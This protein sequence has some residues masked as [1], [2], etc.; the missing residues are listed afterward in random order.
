MRFVKITALLLLVV[1]L[2]A[3]A[4]PVA[5]AADKVKVTFM[6]WEG[7]DTNAVIDKAVESFKAANPDIDVQRLETP[8]TDYSQKIASMTVANQL[9]DIFWA[10]N[11]TEQ[12][13]GAQGALYDWTATLKGDKDLKLEDFAP[14]AIEN[15]T[16]PDGKLYGL[17][18]LMN[19]Y[20]IWYNEDLFKA[21]NVPLPKTGWTYK[22]MF[23]AAK[24]LTQKDGDTVTQYGLVAAFNKGELLDPFHISNC[25]VSN[26]S[27]G[28]MDRV[29]EPTK[30]TADAA[31]KACVKQ[32]ADAVQAGSVSPYT[33]PDDGL[34]EQ[35][36]AGSVPM[37]Y[38]GQWIVPSLIKSAPSFKYGFAPLPVDKDVVEPY[39]A[40]G[41]ASPKTIK[42]PEVVW[43]VAKFLAT[44]LWKSVLPDSPVAPAAH[45]PSSS[46]YFEALAKAGLQSVA[47]GVK[48]ELTAPK[49][50]GIRFT[51]TWSTKANDIWKAVWADMFS[52][53]QP[54]DSTVDKMVTDLNALISSNAP[55]S[56]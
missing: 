35:F 14:G 28:F 25:A 17:P 43:K 10:G 54:I 3:M 6:T 1:A 26:G 13:L 31:Y 24:A 18:T 52:G 56:K 36:I 55:A 53:K 34:V 9:P 46:P 16:S 51:A 37:L 47:D 40:I 5:R 7:A 32:F 15:W 41:I 33:Y 22:D 21:A 20:G 44:D 49:K 19:T 2:A 39:D 42:N 4:L 50:Q 8:T 27:A 30:V 23:D 29:I 45:V 48:Y 38:F 12:Q 11:D